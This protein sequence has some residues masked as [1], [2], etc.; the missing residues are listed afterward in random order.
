MKNITAWSFLVS[1]NQSLDYRTVV[2]PKFMYDA[3]IAGLLAR[4]T[5][6]DLTEK[7]TALYREIHNSKAGDITLI[8][9]IVEA[10]AEDIGTGNGVLK[11]LFGREI[12][13]IEGIAFQGQESN[14]VMTANHLEEAHKR[15][16]GDY[17]KFWEVEDSFSAVASDSF[18]LQSQGEETNLRYIALNPYVAATIVAANKWKLVYQ[19]EEFVSVPNSINSVLD[20]KNIEGIH[21]IAI[22]P[23]GKDIAIRYGKWEIVVWSLEKRGVGDKLPP[24]YPRTRSIYWYPTP[25][26]IDPTGRFLTTGMIGLGECNNVK[27]WDLNTKEPKDVGDL[28]R[29]WDHRITSVA[30]TP[31]SKTKTVITGNA[32]G[33]IKLLEEGLEFGTLSSHNGEVKCLAVDFNNWLLASGDDKREIRLWDL[34]TNKEIWTIPGHSGAVNSL[35]FSPDGKTLVSGSDDQKIRFWNVKTGEESYVEKLGDK[36]TSVVVSSDGNL[37]ASGDYGGNI[38][39]WDFQSKKNIFKESVHSEGLTSVIFTPDGRTLISGGKD[40]KLAVFQQV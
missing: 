8:F 32:D 22:F 21:S 23:D 34:R 3:G 7:G 40:G 18:I 19:S 26:A 4:V 13:L 9:R 33:R 35:A 5:E 11:D 25:I 14:I 6:G 20:G 27:V 28:G 12:S 38:Q 15:I 24:W 10:R 1:R 17:R 16:I 36:I 30:F 37:L 2:A 39:I 29:G 31:D